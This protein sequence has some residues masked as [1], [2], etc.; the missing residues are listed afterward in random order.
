LPRNAYLP[1]RRDFV[2]KETVT[3]GADNIRKTKAT[4]ETSRLNAARAVT[5]AMLD[6]PLRVIS[7]LAGAQAALNAEALAEVDAPLAEARQAALESI[8]VVEHLEDSG[9]KETE[10]WKQA[11]TATVIAQ[12]QVAVLEARRNVLV[13]QNA[14]AAAPANARVEPAKAVEAAQKALVTAEANLKQPVTTA[15][16]PRP[17]PQFPTTSTGRRLAFARWLADRDNPLTARVAMNHVWL[18]HFG[19]AIVPTVFD[20]GRNGRQPTHPALLDWLAAEFMDQRWSMK[21]MHR[22]I[23]TSSAYRMASTSDPAM[24]ALDRDNK[25]LWRMP[26]RQAEAEVVRDCVFYV[27][28]KLD[29]TMGGADID[30]NL[31]LTTP[32]RSLYF[33]HAAEK[34]VEFLKIFDSADVVECYQRKSTVMP[35]QALALANSELTLKHARILARLLAAT[36]NGEDGAVF[37]TAAFERILSRPPTEAELSACVAFLKQ[38][39]EQHTKAPATP[40]TGPD[41]DGKAPSADPALRARESLVHVLL[42]HHDFV[43]IR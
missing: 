30:Q 7:R 23:V 27:A 38:Q 37:T 3:A 2:E 16:T 29:L 35:Q 31:G 10:E 41:P 5:Q 24:V 28:G 4:L 43:T 18:R 11:A 22:L 6:D 40:P 12:R 15:Y 17:L 21:A 9:K 14:H 33:R 32:R 19:Q 34:E 8:L 26:T 13:A 42:N 1:D 20:F 25:Y 39:T 36:K